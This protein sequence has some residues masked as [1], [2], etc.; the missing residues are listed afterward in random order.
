ML[1]FN[2]YGYDVLIGRPRQDE[3]PA[4]TGAIFKEFPATFILHFPPQEISLAQITSL[5][6]EG[7]GGF[8]CS[9]CVEEEKPGCSSTP[10]QVSYITTFVWN[11]GPRLGRACIYESRINSLYL[12]A[13]STSS[14][15]LV[16]YSKC[17]VPR[18]HEWMKDPVCISSQF[19]S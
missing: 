1:S 13:I 3:G 19:L 16:P 9:S 17:H 10:I 14:V 2:T 5:T 15:L 11:K 7:T 12:T 4:L 6:V 8:S 18:Y